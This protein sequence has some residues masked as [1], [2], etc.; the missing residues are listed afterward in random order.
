M[1]GM[2]GHNL[3]TCQPA[4]PLPPA[5]DELGLLAASPRGFQYQVGITGTGILKSSDI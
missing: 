5:W 4:P 1:I 2:G 3:A